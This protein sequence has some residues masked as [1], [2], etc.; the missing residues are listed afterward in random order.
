MRAPPE[1][2]GAAA[3]AFHSVRRGPSRNDAAQPE[4]HRRRGSRV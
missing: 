2:V 4:L 3:A 1:M